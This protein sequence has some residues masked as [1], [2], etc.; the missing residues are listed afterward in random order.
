MAEAMMNGFGGS[1]EKVKSGLD[2]LSTTLGKSIA[3]AITSVIEKI[4][5]LVDWFNALDE[6]DRKL[7]VQIGLIIAAV[8]PVLII[9]GNVVTLIG[10]ITTALGGVLTFVKSKVITEAVKTHLLGLKTYVTTTIFRRLYNKLCK[11]KN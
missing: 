2:V 4:Q 9:L 6:S 3:K 10:G 5:S 11:G 1:I 7:I 8:A